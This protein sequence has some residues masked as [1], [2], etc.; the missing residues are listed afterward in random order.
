MKP[1]I[2]ETI[3]K[4]TNKEGTITYGDKWVNIDMGELQCFIGLLILAGVYKAH[5]EGITHLWNKEDGRPI[6]N[7]S[8]SRNRFTQ[9]SRCLRFDD[10]E[11]RRKNRSPDKLSPIRDVF[12]A[13]ESTLQ[14]AYVAGGNITIDEQLVSFRGRCPFRQYLPS[15]P[16]KFYFGQRVIVKHPML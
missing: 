1:N 5:N 4:L 11:Q 7:K 14:D 12:D 3:L 16:G 6:F 13:W 15:K 10:A 8:M 9:L 2:L